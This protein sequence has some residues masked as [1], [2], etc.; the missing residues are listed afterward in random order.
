MK[1]YTASTQKTFRI[2]DEKMRKLLQKHFDNSDI[3]KLGKVPLWIFIVLLSEIL[4][5]A[6]FGAEPFV[7]YKGHIIVATIF[8][9]WF[10]YDCCKSWKIKRLAIER[11]IIDLIEESE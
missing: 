8:I 2:S 11:F 7:H 1:N 4:T 3:K 9:I 10:A 6:V 5:M